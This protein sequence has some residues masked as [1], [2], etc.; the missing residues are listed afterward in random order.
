MKNELIEATNKEYAEFAE[1]FNENKVQ[2]KITS[3]DTHPPFIIDLLNLT[4]SLSNR[5]KSKKPFIL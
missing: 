4:E 5:I 1:E 2:I 3:T